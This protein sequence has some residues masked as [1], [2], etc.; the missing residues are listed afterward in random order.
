MAAANGIARSRQTLF[1]HSGA[2]RPG[3]SPTPRSLHADAPIGSCDV[4]EFGARRQGKIQ[5]PRSRRLREV[6]RHN[7]AFGRNWLIRCEGTYT[8]EFVEHKLLKS[9][10]YP[11]SEAKMNARASRARKRL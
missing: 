10:R 1:N 5:S 8:A 2:F 7:E 4:F 6:E 11:R 3:V 9:R